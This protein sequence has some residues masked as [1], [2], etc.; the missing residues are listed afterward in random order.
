MRKLI[1]VASA[2][3]LF[4]TASMAQPV[5]ISFNINV[6][7]PPIVISSPLFIFLPS[8]ANA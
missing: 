6:G 1:A 4:Q 3:V 7:A 5:D 2:V 8:I